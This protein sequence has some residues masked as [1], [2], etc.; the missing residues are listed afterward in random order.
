MPLFNRRNIQPGERVLVTAPHSEVC[1]HMRVAGRPMLVEV[2]G[3]HAAQLYT[4]EGRP[5]SAPITHGEAGV[6]FDA[7]AHYVYERDA[8]VAE[9][10]SLHDAS[11]LVWMRQREMEYGSDTYRQLERVRLS[12]KARMDAIRV[13]EGAAVALGVAHAA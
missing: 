11:H 12:L 7:G 9:H 4:P 3:P 10:E 6:F 2:V 13:G 1:M 8:D 5:Y